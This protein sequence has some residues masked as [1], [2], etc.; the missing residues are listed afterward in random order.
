MINTRIP[1]D[2]IERLCSMP[3]WSAMAYAFDNQL[4][5]VNTVIDYAK[6]KFSV[7]YPGNQDEL[8]I[9]TASVNDS[10]AEYVHNLAKS[11]RASTEDDVRLYWANILLT[12]VYEHRSSFD[13]FLGVV[14]EIYTDFD[15][16]EELAPFV[17]YMPSEAPDRGSRK[18][19]E[20]EM[21][22]S[23]GKYVHQFIYSD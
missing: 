11:D 19:N 17:R 15:Y 21:I 22:N 23:I 16:P 14:E 18:A 1:I 13:D 10:I 20:E 8:S 3:S 2:F 12:W 6:K 9:A 5:P 7:G 4:V